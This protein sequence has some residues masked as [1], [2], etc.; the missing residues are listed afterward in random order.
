MEQR[1]LA[2][3]WRAEL[4]RL[5][6]RTVELREPATQDLGPLVDLFSFSDAPRFGIAAPV[7]ELAI[8][9]YIDLTIQQ[10]AAGVGFS[11]VITLG[12]QR[13]VMGLIRVRQLDVTFETA[14]WEC[15]IAPSSRG[16]GVFVEA[17]GLV[18]SFAFTSVGVHRLESRVL[19]EN[20]RANR[21]LQKLGAMQEGIL[22]RS[23]RRGDDDLDQVLWAVLSEDWRDRWVP[24]AARVH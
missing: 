16:T 1:N 4:P 2:N 11:Y 21:A 22:R 19:L 20:G 23:V 14:E 15:L 10:R 7:T 6:G 18:G 12:A 24:S 13:V 17:T 5:R 3:E 8:Q 9:R